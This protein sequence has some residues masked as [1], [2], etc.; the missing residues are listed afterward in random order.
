MSRSST[1]SLLS[2]ATRMRSFSA[3][4]ICSVPKFGTLSCWSAVSGFRE[5]CSC[6]VTTVSDSDFSVRY[7]FFC[8]MVSIRRKTMFHFNMTFPQN[9]FSMTIPFASWFSDE[10]RLPMTSGVRPPIPYSFFRNSIFSFI[11][12]SFVRK[13]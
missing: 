13:L 2:I 8:I 5:L 4:A 10:N 6:S 11:L 3:D 9:S 12:C 7:W 1:S